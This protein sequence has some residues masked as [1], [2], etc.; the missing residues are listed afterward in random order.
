MTNY[1][2]VGMTKWLD[3]NMIASTGRISQGTALNIIF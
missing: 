3:I 2:S 1:D